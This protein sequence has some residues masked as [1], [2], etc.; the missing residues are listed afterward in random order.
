MSLAGSA[1]GSAEQSLPSPK[2]YTDD[3]KDDSMKTL[4]KVDCLM[5]WRSGDGSLVH[6]TT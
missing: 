3:R 4:S 6:S 2:A 5:M 1:Y